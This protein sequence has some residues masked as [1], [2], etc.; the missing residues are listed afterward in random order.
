MIVVTDEIVDRVVRIETQNLVSRLEPYAARPGNP[1]GVFIARFGEATAFAA[2]EIPVRFFN[3][4]LSV[5]PESV[6]H[7][8]DILAFYAKHGVSPAFE[9]VPGRMPESFGAELHRRGLAMVQFHVGLVRVPEE[10]PPMKGVEIEV[11][12]A[13]EAPALD[14]FLDVFVEGWNGPGEHERAKANMRTWTGNDEWTFYIAQ[15]DGQDA[16]AAILD[17]RGRTAMLGSA[18]TKNSFRGRGVQQ[19]LLR[20]R[21]SDAARRGADLLVGGA[22]WG[23]ASVRNQ[24]RCGFSTAFTRGVWVRP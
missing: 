20:R 1:S 14:R 10:M 12:D 6:E 8:D 16:G 11:I 5:V 18:S 3:S 17:L 22:Y 21:S 13:R 24:Q 23:T 15:I 4:V 7:L 2:T 19:A 9:I